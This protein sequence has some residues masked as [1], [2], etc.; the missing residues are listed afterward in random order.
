[1]RERVRLQFQL[2]ATNV[3]NRQNWSNPNMDLSNPVARGRITEVGTGA[4]AG[5]WDAPGPREMRLGLRIDF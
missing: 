3:F 4:G 2:T 5:G 1:M